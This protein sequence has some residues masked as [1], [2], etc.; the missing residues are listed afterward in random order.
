MIYLKIETKNI[1]EDAKAL[2]SYLHRVDYS[3]FN[4]INIKCV[5]DRLII[6]LEYN[7]NHYDKVQYF[8]TE[9]VAYCT[10]NKHFWTEPMQVAKFKDPIE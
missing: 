1:I 4:V 6:E 5:N 3:G 7:A 8:L 9:L 10:R 2:A